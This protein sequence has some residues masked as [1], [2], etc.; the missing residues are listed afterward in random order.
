VVDPGD[1]EGAAGTPG[2]EHLADCGI[3][4]QRRERVYVRDAELEHDGGDER[5]ESQFRW[6][7]AFSQLP[8][9]SGGA[10][11]GITGTARPG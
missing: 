9:L 8:E 11:G 10:A 1:I 4:E 5:R 3:P 6:S 7:L 2:V